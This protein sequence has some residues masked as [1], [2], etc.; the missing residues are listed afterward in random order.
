[1]TTFHIENKL[2]QKCKTQSI[3]YIYNGTFKLIVCIPVNIVFLQKHK[4]KG[5]NDEFGQSHLEM[6]K[7]FGDKG[8]TKIYEPF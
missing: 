6:D 5:E 2:T 7:V 4:L 1:M 3:C 8:I